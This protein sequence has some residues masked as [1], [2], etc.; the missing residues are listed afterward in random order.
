M[1]TPSIKLSRTSFLPEN[2]RVETLKNQSKGRTPRW[3]YHF[4]TEWFL[5][6]L[7]PGNHDYDIEFR[8]SEDSQRFLMNFGPARYDQYL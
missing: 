6:E 1:L 5:T 2:A 3:R 8:P 7:F 4:S